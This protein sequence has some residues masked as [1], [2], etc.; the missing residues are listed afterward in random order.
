MGSAALDLLEIRRPVEGATL[1]LSRNTGSV[2]ARV[3]VS[4]A[5]LAHY[6]IGIE[7]SIREV[8]K[9]QKWLLE[10]CGEDLV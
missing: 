2:G 6:D 5:V 1:E 10:N 9:L 4:S 8:R 7:L 3:R